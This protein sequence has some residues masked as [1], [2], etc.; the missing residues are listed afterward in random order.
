LSD[1]PSGLQF[2]PGMVKAFLPPWPRYIPKVPTNVAGP[3]VLQAF[4]PPP[5][6]TPDQEKLNLLC[7]VRSLDAY[8][9]RAALWRKLDQLFDCFG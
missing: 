1:G 5:F 4:C 2:A 7:P 8:L 3:V 9:N 6:N